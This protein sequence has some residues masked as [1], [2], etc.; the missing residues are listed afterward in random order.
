MN[1]YRIVNLD[2][3]SV[4]WHSWR[5]WKVGA[6]MAPTIMGE[7]PFETAL[8]LWERLMEGREVVENEHM[9]RGKEGEIR[10]RFLMNG[11]VPQDPYMPVCMESVAYPWMIA[12]LDGWSNTI[13]P[14][15]LEIK[16]PQ[17]IHKEVPS[18]Y[19][20]QLQH[21]MVVANVDTCLYVSY[22]GEHMYP[23]LVKKD[24]EYCERLF[25]A[26]KEFY[27]CLIHFK[28]PEATSKDFV[29]VEIPNQLG[30]I[31][32]YREI[33]RQQ[34]ELEREK[35]ELRT[36][37]LSHCTHNRSTIGDLRIQKILRKGNIDYGSIEALK[38][39]DLEKYR[40]PNVESWRIS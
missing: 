10:V 24:P 28:P 40:K 4:E 35:L 39:V 11:S 36:Y 6:S 37:M 34:Q 17:K 3:N 15:I 12:S 23:L 14:H 25:I 22:D 8:Q 27:E 30:V 9:A 38:E 13:K 26:E 2:Q 20:G 16:C 1:A 32:R 33:E 21:Q 31:N 7:N 19:K 29:S 18:Y 5:K